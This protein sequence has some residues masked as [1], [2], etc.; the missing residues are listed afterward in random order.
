MIKQLLI[1]LGLLATI[2]FILF[3]LNPNSIYQINQKTAQFAPLQSIPKGLISLKAKDCGICHQ[4]IYQEWQTSL[5]SRAYRDPFF[6]A[7]LKKDKDDPTCL[8]CHTPLLNQS[9]V[10]LS[11]ASGQ[12]D[13]LTS[14]DNPH[15]DA[16]LQQEGVTCAGCHLR[17]GIIYGPYKKTELNAPHPVAYDKK[18]RQKTLCKQCHEV[19]SKDFSLMNDGICSTGM[20]SDSGIWAAKGFICQDCHMPQ[21]KRP[22]MAGYPSREGKQHLWPG[23][24][25]NHQLQ[26]VF[27]FKAHKIDDTIQITITNSG[28]GHKAPTGDTDRF[29]VLDFYWRTDKGKHIALDTIEFKRQVIWQP[30][31]FVLSD[32]R[33]APGASTQLSVI[34]PSESGTL[35]VDASYH[36]MT[37]RSLARLKDKFSLKN[38][39]PIQRVFIKQQKIEL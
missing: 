15:F 36:I 24:Y 11:S 18:F 35:Y 1:T 13:D 19:P 21:I 12:Y 10:I 27:T 32:N 20:E 2:I 38:E 33:L 31:M 30:I 23:G 34:A 3:L 9:P 16:Q 5:H 25:S 39:P 28:A 8:V 37:E 22:L 14:T 29:I 17:E 6:Q 26:K 4:E 7:Y